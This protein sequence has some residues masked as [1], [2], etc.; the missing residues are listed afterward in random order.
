MTLFNNFDVAQLI[1][2]FLDSVC[3]PT[4]STRDIFSR[5]PLMLA[6]ALVGMARE[7]H[8]IRWAVSLFHPAGLERRRGPWKAAD[9]SLFLPEDIL[10]RDRVVSA[11]DKHWGAS[12][13]S[14]HNDPDGEAH[15]LRIHA[16][17]DVALVIGRLAIDACAESLRPEGSG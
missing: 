2:S 5:C 16:I 17:Q 8:Q 15:W 1:K 7:A 12:V 3:N 9:I 4:S 6:S 14:N 13:R 11:V 10:F